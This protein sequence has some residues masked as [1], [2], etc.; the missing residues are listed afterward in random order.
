MVGLKHDTLAL[1]GAHL[2]AASCSLPG[3]PV[4]TASNPLLTGIISPLIASFL[5]DRI[6]KMA[7]TS[8]NQLR[9]H[10]HAGTFGTSGSYLLI[11]FPMNK[12]W[13]NLEANNAAIKSFTLQFRFCYEYGI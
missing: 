9:V 2:V 7:P 1:A 4:N 11:S 3:R 5:I 8:L 12:S 10:Q 13:M 6:S